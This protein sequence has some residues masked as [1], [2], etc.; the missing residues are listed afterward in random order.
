MNPS[1]DQVLTKVLIGFGVAETCVSRS[2][3]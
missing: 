1:I 2:A 3:T